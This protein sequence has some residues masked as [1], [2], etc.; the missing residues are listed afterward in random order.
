MH[1]LVDDTGHIWTRGDRW[2]F[3]CKDISSILKH[4]KYLELGFPTIYVHVL[5]CIQLVVARI[6]S[7]SVVVQWWYSGLPSIRE[8][9]LCRTWPSLP[10][11]SRRSSAAVHHIFLCSVMRVQLAQCMHSIRHS[12]VYRCIGSA[13]HARGRLLE[14]SS[15]QLMHSCCVSF[16]TMLVTFAGHRSINVYTT[17]GFNR[18]LRIRQS[19][20][21]TGSVRLFDHFE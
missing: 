1:F 18:A 4:M 13:F 11:P 2:E 6:A 8:G 12:S 5:L 3:T 14:I 7:T 17:C 10:F 9:V 20:L 16:M 15:C 19:T 21:M